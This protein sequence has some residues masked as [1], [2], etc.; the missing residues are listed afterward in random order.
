MWDQDM[1]VDVW[2]ITIW[3]S[4]SSNR[5]LA[6]RDRSAAGSEFHLFRRSFKMMFYG[7]SKKM[8]NTNYGTYV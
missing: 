4:A 7:L 8:I 6:S 1:K 2:D 3:K 5:R